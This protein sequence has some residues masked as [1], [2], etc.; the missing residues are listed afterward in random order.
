M[1]EK[2]RYE[3]TEQHK[4]RLEHWHYHGNVD[5]TE[6]F[7][8]INDKCKELAQ[9]IM[10]MTPSCDKQEVAISSIENCRMWA[11]SAIAVHECMV[12]GGCRE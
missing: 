5:D 6:R 10:E 12:R 8:L 9:M 3:L 11:N 1:G 2:I 7:S 4:L